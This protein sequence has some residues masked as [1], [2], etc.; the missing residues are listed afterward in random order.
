MV[1]ARAFTYA[2]FDESE[3][4]G[5]DLFIV[6][7]SHVETYQDW[8]MPLPAEMRG[9]ADCL[10]IAGEPCGIPLNGAAGAYFRYDVPGGEEEPYYLFFGK[11]SLHVAGQE[12]AVDNEAAAAAQR[13]L[14]LW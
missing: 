10:H 8:F 7:L 3:L 1:K 6:P 2:M 12:N 9:Y 14:A 4:A 13:L 11:A 5:A